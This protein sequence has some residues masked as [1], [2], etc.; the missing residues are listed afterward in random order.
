MKRQIKRKEK[1]EQEYEEKMHRNCETKQRQ[2]RAEWRKWGKTRK[3]RMTRKKQEEQ[4]HLILLNES[5]KIKWLSLRP[6]N[7]NFGLYSHS[8]KKIICFI[9]TAH[10]RLRPIREWNVIGCILIFRQNGLLFLAVRT[11]M[12]PWWRRRTP[13]LSRDFV[14]GFGRGSKTSDWRRNVLEAKGRRPASGLGMADSL[15]SLI[16]GEYFVS[17]LRYSS[18]C[19]FR[20]QMLHF[21]RIRD[22]FATT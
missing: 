21:I 2:R 18:G 17:P 9:G 19:Y 14:W 15:W 1:S 12:I 11:K 4:N 8:N 3:P 5:R 20:K 6:F 13:A 22:C 10:A 16:K 7:W